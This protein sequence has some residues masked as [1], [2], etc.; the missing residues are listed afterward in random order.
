MMAVTR[1]GPGCAAL[2]LLSVNPSDIESILAGA[3]GDRVLVN[4]GAMAGCY[5]KDSTEAPAACAQNC[6]SSHTKW[7]AQRKARLRCGGR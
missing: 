1:G 3:A 4:N 7:R 6:S 2:A 5:H